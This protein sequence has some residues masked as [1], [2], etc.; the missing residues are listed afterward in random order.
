MPDKANNY[1]TPALSVLEKNTWSALQDLLAISSQLGLGFPI[2]VTADDVLFQPLVFLYIILWSYDKCSVPSY[3][4]ID[5]VKMCG[6]CVYNIWKLFKIDHLKFEL[7]IDPF[8]NFYKNNRPR[9]KTQCRR[10]KFRRAWLCSA[11]K[12][13]EINKS[14]FIIHLKF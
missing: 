13:H 3:S 1:L 2:P 7:C 14:K 10:F 12:L 4:I 11:V 5:N 9:S 6:T 8:S